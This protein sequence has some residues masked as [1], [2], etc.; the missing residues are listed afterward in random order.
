MFRYI[1]NI[2]GTGEKRGCEEV[3]K[4]K[5][6]SGK[7]GRRRIIFLHFFVLLL[8]FIFHFSFP[9]SSLAGGQTEI[10]SDNL[11]YLSQTNS[12]HAKGSVRIVFENSTLSADE[13]L[14]DNNT[15]NAVATGNVVYEDSE[16]II[17]ADRIELN[18][19]TELGTVYNS[20]TFYKKQNFH[21]RADNVKKTGT[22]NFYLDKATLT[23]CDAEVPSWHF[24]GKDIKTTQHESLS[25][26]D[27]KFYIKS[28]PVLYTPYFW[29][30]ITKERQTG[31]LFPSFGYSSKQGQYFKQGVF[32]AFKE[33]QDA[34]LYLDY[35][36]EK[37]LAGGLDYRY[38]LTPESNGEFWI[39]HARDNEPSRDLFEVKSYHN[40]KFPYNISS[41]L[42]LHAVNEPDYYETLD[43]TSFKRMGLS[44]WEQDP[45]GFS[46]EER[47]QK[48][49]ESDLQ[50]SRPYYGGRTYLLAQTRQSL[51]GS[52]KEIPQILPETGFIINTTS[53]GPV[54]YNGALKAVNF[55][56]K[57]GQDGLRVDV[58]PNIYLS[59][60]RLIN[61]T[62][63]IGLRETAYFLDT[64]VANKS[65]L[66]MDLGSAL[67]TKYYKKYSSS[68]HIIE[69]S[70]EYVY[71]TPYDTDDIPSFDSTDSIPRTS[72]LLYSFTNRI[73]GLRPLNLESRF[74]LSQSYSLL[75]T[76]K[77]FSPILAEAVVSSDKADIHLN[78]SYDVHNRILTETIASFIVKDKK[79][80]IGMGKNYRRSSSLDQIDF[81]AGLNNPITLFKKTLP[82]DLHGKLWYD[83][84]GNGVQKFN[85][86]TVYTHQ[87]WALSLSLTK[88]PDEYQIIFA[89]ELKGLGTFALGRL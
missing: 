42:K 23:S 61:F 65:R 35:S 10:S 56:R 86:K 58:Y 45:F 7:G 13:M 68:I 19:K 3:R 9:I 60:G 78:A 67:T 62:Q 25:A 73:S 47:L 2:K 27:A 29:A 44:S 36:S 12:Y 77:P 5:T 46:S 81:E 85:V 32:W 74:R 82:V 41:Y 52:S 49:L 72:S 26:W 79:G 14:L 84:N 51:E 66:L 34:T 20:Y 89:F 1:V 18:L 59:Y 83:L 53:T 80:Y 54:S 22:R 64:P 70:L 31:L 37:R 30:P 48:Y 33:N 4:K 57:E 87:C 15:S 55:W 40:H 39:Y 50:L 75:D 24:S 28:V 11:E 71:I 43:S 17:K 6:I 76:D 69:P 8:F 63:K 38:V 16:A 88:R 21:V